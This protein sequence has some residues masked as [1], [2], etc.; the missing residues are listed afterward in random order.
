VLTIQ[1]VCSELS[2]RRSVSAAANLG[3]QFLFLRS[4]R[5]FAAIPFLLCLCGFASSREILYLVRKAGK[6]LV[7]GEGE[8]REQRASIV[9]SGPQHYCEMIRGF[10]SPMELSTWIAASLLSHFPYR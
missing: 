8:A 4:L 3:S 1:N 7:E 9:I 6:N 10:F 2:L 5:S